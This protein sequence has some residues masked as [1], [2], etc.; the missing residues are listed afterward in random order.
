MHWPLYVLFY[1]IVLNVPFWLA[2]S[3]TGLML[4]GWFCI[5]FMLLGIACLFLPNV[6]APLLVLLVIGID[7]VN[8]ICQTYYLSPSQLLSNM[9]GAIS[10]SRS[11]IAC[12][13]L[14]LVLALALAAAS[15]YLALRPGESRKRAALALFFLS[16]GFIGSDYAQTVVDNHAARL[17]HGSM[18]AD[19]YK[20]DHFSRSHLSRMPV[21]SLTLYRKLLDAEIAGTSGTPQPS[22]AAFS[23]VLERSSFAAHG[24]TGARPD[25]VLVLVESWGLAG[26]PALRSAITAPYDDAGVRSR[27]NLVQGQ[28]PFFG[29]TVVGEARELC[30]NTLGFRVLRSSSAQLASCAPQRLA[31][32]GYRTTAVHGMEGHLFDRVT[33]YRTIG[34][35]E[36]WFRSQL[37]ALGLPTCVGPFIGTC[38]SAIADWIG[39]RLRGPRDSAPQ[40]IYWVTLNSHLP[41]PTPAPLPHP[42]SCGF[43][44]ALAASPALCSWF[45]LETNVHQSV[46]R[47]AA[48]VQRPTVFILVGDHA[49]PFTSPD[50]R[51]QFSA[52]DVPYIALVPNQ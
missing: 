35:Q 31:A 22:P 52:E 7:I 11:R 46:A 8:A 44:S 50:L 41:V 10:F 29:P 18:V 38:D 28:V 17:S 1:A 33:W 37:S 14:V 13:A 27:Y 26:D 3:T 2:A 49:P 23:E 15:R 12:G 24:Q 45:Q 6:L 20:L 34:F 30:G 40:F 19:S 51:A 4:R 32:T 42:A 9:D 16:L 43:S 47:L 36:T 39:N 5:P 21:R 25:I 48:S